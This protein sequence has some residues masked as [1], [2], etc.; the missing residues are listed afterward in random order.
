MTPRIDVMIAGAQKAGTTS[1]ARYLGSLPSI[2]THDDIEFP[3]FVEPGRYRSYDDAFA[4]HFRGRPGAHQMVLAKSAGVMFVE[5]GTERLLEHNPHCRVIAILRHP[6]DRAWSAY[7]FMRRVG[8]EISATFEEALELEPRRLAND[9][10]RYHQL[11][12]RHRGDYLP[13]LRRMSSIVPRD[14]LY[15]CLLDDLRAD[16]EALCRHLVAWLGMS[17]E[18]ALAVAVAASHNE[19]AGVRSTRAARALRQPAPLLRTLART[20]PPGLRAGIRRSTWDRLVQANERPLSVPPMPESTRTELVAWFQ[21]RNDA[22]AAH[23]GRDLS[24]W[25][26]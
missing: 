13:Q 9:F 2:F 5:D 25:S 23:L 16:P 21:P 20:I 6:V 14:Q 11:A 17:V 1:L 18:P 10:G 15:I 19:S 24:A 26:A 3:W 7:W 4:Q 22:L 12:Y 8:R